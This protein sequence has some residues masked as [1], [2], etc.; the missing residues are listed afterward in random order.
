MIM[1]AP[2]STGRADS[3]S[4]TASRSPASEATATIGNVSIMA[5]RAPGYMSYV[6][7]GILRGMT[8]PVRFSSMSSPL[9]I[10]GVHWSMGFFVVSERH[11]TQPWRSPSDMSASVRLA[12]SQIPL[13]AAPARWTEYVGAQT[14]F[15]DFKDQPEGGLI[16]P[17]V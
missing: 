4:E 16:N 8:E 13:C 15:E 11:R 1:A 7:A 17:Q 3:S 5:T 14:G 2:H 12:L 9:L 6:V 10:R